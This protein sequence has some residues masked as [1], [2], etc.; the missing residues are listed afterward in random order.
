MEILHSIWYSRNVIDVDWGL[1]VKLALPGKVTKVHSKIKKPPTSHFPRQ[2]L[3]ATLSSVKF[4]E[5]FNFEVKCLISILFFWACL[6]KNNKNQEIN[7]T[8]C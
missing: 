5:T 2:L 8:C 7:E 1:V 3:S 4:G 6:S